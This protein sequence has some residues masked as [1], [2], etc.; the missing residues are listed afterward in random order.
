MIQQNTGN[1]EEIIG[2][3][4]HCID[5]DGVGVRTLVAFHGCLL[6]CLYCL[7][8]QCH[9]SFDKSR[10]MSPEEV[11][12]ILKKDE[13]YFMATNGGVTFG[14]G[15]PLLKSEFIAEV[16]S[17]GANKWNTTLET[18]LC[19]ERHHLERLLPWIDEYIVD[20]KDM[21]NR[22][23][24]SYTGRRSDLM[25]SNLQYL[26]D[27]GK[28][29]RILCRIP[30]IPGYNTERDC[31]WSED[32]LIDM[33]LTRFETFTYIKLP[34]SESGIGTSDH[35]R[36]TLTLE[37]IRRHKEQKK[38]LEKFMKEWGKNTMGKIIDDD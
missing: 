32:K 37:D 22:I 4:R 1:K 21:N 34:S 27:N 12:E 18:S 15:E 9:S 33:G 29:D 2:I 13:L 25:K 36:K 30:L 23:Y 11:M 14:G 8:P 19:V 24:Q 10:E 31:H 26:V 38:A 6:R 28:A 35:C 17:L 3:K 5:T 7:N 16:L 20:I